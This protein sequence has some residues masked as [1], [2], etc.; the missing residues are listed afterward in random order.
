MEPSSS[1]KN[2]YLIPQKWKR[3]I[4]GRGYIPMG[5]VHDILERVSVR[6]DGMGNISYDVFHKILSEETKRQWDRI[7]DRRHL[8]IVSGVIFTILGFILGRL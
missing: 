2:D 7:I 8:N 4:L 3:F 6:I 5:D 1:K